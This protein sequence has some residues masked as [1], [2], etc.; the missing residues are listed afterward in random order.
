M[1]AVLFVSTIPL[2]GIAFFAWN[3]RAVRRAVPQLVCFAVGA[4]LGAAFFQLIPEAYE[5]AR[6]PRAVPATVLLGHATFFA[7]E[8]LLHGVHGHHDAHR[9]AHAHGLTHAPGHAPGHAHGAPTATPARARR[10]ALVTLNLLGDA[11]HNLLDGMLIAAT[12]LTDPAVGV[13]T[14]VAVS[15]HE[16]PRELG[17]FGVFVHGGVTARRALAYNMWTALLAALG[18]AATLVLG[19]RAAGLAHALLPFAAG[20]FLYI[21]A[22]L[23]VPLLRRPGTRRVLAVRAGLLGLGL[24]ATGVPALFH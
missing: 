19:T 15:L 4:L 8:W 16:V 10:S 5:R 14:T 3:E 23:L 13:L 9:G 22:S 24:A 20:N 1:V 21:A 18:A 17:S 7:L 11:L 6:A 12:F 2:V